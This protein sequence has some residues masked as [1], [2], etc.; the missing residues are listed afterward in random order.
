MPFLGPHDMPVVSQDRRI[1]DPDPNFQT[2]KT[3]EPQA[4]QHL[5][6]GFARRAHLIDPR[7]TERARAGDNPD[8]FRRSHQGRRI[9]PHQ[10]RITGNRRSPAI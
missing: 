10:F 8:A 9:Y 2:R 6:N 3:V 4:G 1:V 5:R 7:Q